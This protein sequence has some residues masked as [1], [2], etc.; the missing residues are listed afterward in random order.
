MPSLGVGGWWGT[1][2]N[3]SGDS[4]GSELLA[5]LPFLPM[6]RVSGVASAVVATAS[7]LEISTSSVIN[8]IGN[9]YE[10][11]DWNSN[12]Y[13]DDAA[14]VDALE[15]DA[16]QTWRGVK[17]GL[18]A[19]QSTEAT[20]P[21]LGST[22]IVF[23][24]DVLVA[25]STGFPTGDVDIGFVAVLDLGAA[26]IVGATAF[27]Y[28]VG[29]DNT[30]FGFTYTGSRVVAGTGSPSLLSL[31]ADQPGVSDISVY[32]FHNAVANTATGRLGIAPEVTGSITASPNI[33]GTLNIGAISPSAFFANCVI[34]QL[35][36][37][38]SLDDARILYRFFRFL[39]GIEVIQQPIIIP[40]DMV[41]VT[42]GESNSGG[43]G[44]NT[45]LA[46]D[47]LD[48]NPDIQILNNTTLTLQD[49]DI[50]TNNLLGHTGLTNGTTHGW[51]AGIQA[52]TSGQCYLI[53]CGQG[54]SRIDQWADAGTY[55]NTFEARIDAFEALVT[56][57]NYRV[58]LSFGI[59][60]ANAG[61]D[62]TSWRTATEDWISRIRTKLGSAT[63]HIYATKIMNNA[64]ARIAIN[65][66]LDA[67]AAADTNFFL[68]DSS[69]SIFYPLVDNSHWNSLGLK[70]I[71]RDFLELE[72]TT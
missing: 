7:V 5:L 58:W 60:D 27:S 36:Y 54:G 53:K 25:P 32:G 28:A 31:G 23:D 18:V 55:Q 8:T 33:S 6:S 68:V 42:L 21:I 44:L 10:W 17:T 14:T 65:A 34:R 71:A 4:I 64:P 30:R 12:V 47:E 11:W 45:D 67:I 46:A 50:G 49:L 39:E 40:D 24:Q 35:V 38:E 3:S 70:Q 72:F 48:P 9:C 56:T 22:G 59:N 37:T 13:T 26:Q 16:V 63:I 43:L 41:V 20:R 15:S 1:A 52:H 29:N 61:T 62:P 69:N 57:R 66:Q 19:A 51:E 2:S